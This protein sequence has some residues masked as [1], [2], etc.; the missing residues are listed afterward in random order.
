MR[1]TIVAALIVAALPMLGSDN[2]SCP[3]KQPGNPASEMV[4]KELA[5]RV[6]ATVGT[7]RRLHLDATAGMPATR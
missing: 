6:K 5:V 7:D 1:Y 2:S 4:V 3:L